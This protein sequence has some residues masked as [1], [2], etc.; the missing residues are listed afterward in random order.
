[1]GFDILLNVVQNYRKKIDCIINKVQK[2]KNNCIEKNGINA[3]GTRKNGAKCTPY[4]FC[5][6][7]GTQN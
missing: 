6:D 3:G 1:M 7:N 4:Y 5:W 2:F